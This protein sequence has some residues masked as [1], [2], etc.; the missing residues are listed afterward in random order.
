MVRKD[1]GR[2]AFAHMVRVTNVPS[3]PV[4]PPPPVPQGGAAGCAPILAICCL[5]FILF[6]IAATIVLA[7][8]PVYLPAKNAAKSNIPYYCTANYDGTLG[9]DG[10]LDATA[11]AQ[12]ARSLE[13]ALHK[14]VN[15]I[16]INQVRVAT[17]STRRRRRRGF[18]SLANRDASLSDG[19]SSRSI[20]GSNT[21][22]KGATIG[23]IQR[24]YLTLN[25]AGLI[26]EPNVAVPT[27]FI[28]NGVLENPTLSFSCTRTPIIIPTLSTSTPPVTA[29]LT[30]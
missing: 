3:V 19:S 4:A 12:I 25:A 2:P 1:S 8:I 10:D 13:Q 23:G 24:L 18:M 6:L 21:D 15:S 17:T 5:L 29:K 9:G 22:T 20:R 26:N 28:Y 14:P 27:S 7:L 11:R 30:G 16:T